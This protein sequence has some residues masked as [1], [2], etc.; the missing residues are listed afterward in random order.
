MS[1][2]E[3]IV[4]SSKNHWETELERPS[5]RE[6]PLKSKFQWLNSLTMFHTLAF[7]GINM[8]IVFRS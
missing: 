6:S 3:H 5:L 1:H 4:H 2:S 7:R 8:I